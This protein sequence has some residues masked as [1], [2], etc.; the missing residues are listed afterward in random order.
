[1]AKERTF[2]YFVYMMIAAIKANPPMVASG[3]T[4][5]W[6]ESE[7]GT[8]AGTG[9]CPVG[10]TTSEGRDQRVLIEGRSGWSWLGPGTLSAVASGSCSFC[11]LY[12]SEYDWGDGTGNV[13]GFASDVVASDTDVVASDVVASGVAA[14]DVYTGRETV[15]VPYGTGT[16]ELGAGMEE[17]SSHVVATVGSSV[18]ELCSSGHEVV[19]LAEAGG[20]SLGVVTV[21][22]LED[23]TKVDVVGIPGADPTGVMIPPAGCS[24]VGIPGADPTGV[25]R[26]PAGCSVTGPWSD[27]VQS[28]ELIK[29]IGRAKVEVVCMVS[30]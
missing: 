16:P 11:E 19:S 23:N 14:S 4:M 21:A 2:S 18:A 9:G 30:I 22:G 10:S 25:M 5:L 27:V 6:V 24:V 28:S 26:P 29:V 1:M 17:S 12:G 20:I 13:A 7:P 3:G 15:V 8:W